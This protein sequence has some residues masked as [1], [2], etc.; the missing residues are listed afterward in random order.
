MSTSQK[1]INQYKKLRSY[2]DGFWKQTKDKYPAEIACSPGCSICCELQSVNFLEAFVIAEHRGRGGS[3]APPP[4]G[5]SC[6]F[7]SDN[8]CRIY[9]VR[10]LICRTHGL[11]LRSKEFSG[12]T[13]PS[14]PFNFTSAD[15][16]AL[17]DTYA[18]DIDAITAGLAKLNAAFCMLLGGVKK[19]KERIALRDLASGKIGTY[20]IKTA[21]T[22]RSRQ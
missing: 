6:P 4:S 10:P 12:R 5:T 22:S 8:R 1:I 7:L 13:A 15:P 19:A 11:L 17:S 2:C 9:P 16:A 21:G 3:S 18:L 20:Q 14:C